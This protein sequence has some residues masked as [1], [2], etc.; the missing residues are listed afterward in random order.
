MTKNILTIEQMTT[1]S[2]STNFASS[3]AAT[4]DTKKTTSTS[5]TAQSM[6]KPRMKWSGEEDSIE[7]GWEDTDTGTLTREEINYIRWYNAN[8]DRKW[9]N[10]D[11]D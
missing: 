1:T 7:R 2:T 6:K 11:E 3:S 10:D 9:H 8:K 5:S 4:V